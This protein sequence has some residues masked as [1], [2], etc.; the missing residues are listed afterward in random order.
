MSEARA[1]ETAPCVLERLRAETR[2]E[3][4]AIERSPLLQELFSGNPRREAYRTLLE[5]KYGFHRPVERILRRSAPGLLAD[6]A[7][8][9]LLACDLN[10]LGL[11]LGDLAA[12]PEARELPPL[13]SPAARLG[14]M[15]VLEGA[16]LGGQ[17]ILNRLA[18]AP[19]P[20]I[21]IGTRFF[22][23]HGPATGRR[24]QAFRRQLVHE[25]PDDSRARDTAVAAAADTFTC[26]RRWIEGASFPDL[27][28]T[29]RCP[30]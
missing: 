24:G 6:R 10:A 17:V 23:G 27:R 15:Y 16:T 8:S 30:A 19:D 3:H 21:R 28:E 12:L 25:M 11:S 1:D 22:R 26:L 2:T 13:D 18:A 9:N 5:R 14:V 7:R 20:A 29:R 4:D